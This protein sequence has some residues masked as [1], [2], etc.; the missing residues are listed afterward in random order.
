MSVERFRAELVEPPLWTAD[1]PGIGGR[2]RTQP[3]DFVVREIPAYPPDGGAGH[4]FVSMRKRG[5]STH[6]AMA[7]VGRACGVAPR[8]IG[9]AGRKDRDAVTE[10]W[11][12]LPAQATAA[13]ATFSHP[14]I[15]LG[16][17]HPH[18]HKLR[19]GHLRGNA[20]ELTI[21]EIAVDFDEARRRVAA[22]VA[23]LHELGGVPNLFGPQRFGK[24]GVSLD[25]GLEAMRRGKGGARGNMIVA[26]GQAGL[27]NLYALLRREQWRTVLAGD[28]LKKADTGGLFTCADPAADQP[29]LQRGEV[30][31]TGPIFG[32][33]TRRAQRGTPAAALEEETLALAG[34]DEGAL[35]A[36]GKRAQGTRRALTMPLPTVE[37]AGTPDGALHVSFALRSGGYATTVCGELMGPR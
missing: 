14:D 36:L 24:G 12:S 22:K 2:L 29:R 34:V 37:V 23:R 5:V 8:D 25:R 13:I 35:Q 16:P 32:S 9:S 17:P 20:F 11:L 15:E 6:D 27:F 33:R 10:Q 4:V 3:E 18:S 30:L 7:A 26:A 19:M 1:L 21:R 28:V 31:I